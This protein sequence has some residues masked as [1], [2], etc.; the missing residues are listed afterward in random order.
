MANNASSNY[1]KIGVLP[2]EQ[3][4]DGENYVSFQDTVLP[5]GQIKGLNLYWEGK[6]H[7][8]SP[9]TPTP[10]AAPSAV[11]NPHPNP[12]EYSLHESV[13]Y[14][15][16]WNN[17]KNPSGL[18]IPSSK[19]SSELWQYLEKEYL[20]VSQL[21]RQCKKDALKDC[22]Y[23]EGVDGKISREGGYAKKMQLLRKAAMDAGAHI[24]EERF[25]SL[26]RLFPS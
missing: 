19:T 2:E 8:P 7:V 12:L 21:A 25:I 6:V 16:I 1:T 17:I 10:Y 11:N 15:T 14:L 13:A 9:N 23:V 26:P 4:F 20:L 5:N 24:P 3:H 18:S 22:K